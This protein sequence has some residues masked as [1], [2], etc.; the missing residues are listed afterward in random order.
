MNPRAQNPTGPSLL[1]RALSSRLR[2][3]IER[4]PGPRDPT[5]VWNAMQLLTGTLEML[6]EL[7]DTYGDV[8]HFKLL[9]SDYYMLNHPDDIEDAIARQAGSMARDEYID[10]LAASVRDALDGW[11]PDH[12]LISFHG[13]PKR[14]A[15]LGDPYPQHCYATAGALVS[16]MGWAQGRVTVSFQSL[17]GR[18][19]WLRP[20]TD[21]TLRTLGRRRFSRLAVICPG[22][23]A[24]CLET[25]EEMGMTNR[26]LY[27]AAEV[28]G[29][30]CVGSGAVRYRDRLAAHGA[31]VPPDD[32]PRH[33]PRAV[34]HARLAAGFGP[35]A[36]IEPVYVRAP[37]ARP[38]TA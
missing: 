29:K 22:F 17:Y 14:F 11:D 8:V 27:E 33:V 10:A 1:E 32:D 2:G 9:V 37:D 20:Y 12:V 28:D 7:A 38:R 15:I 31:L 24:D 30:L 13:V 19:E 36:E 25:L 34:L 4:P 5:G 35:V 6:R 3:D 26:E 21:E 16:A 18:E 23:T